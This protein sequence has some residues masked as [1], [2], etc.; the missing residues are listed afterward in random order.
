MS[1]YLTKNMSKTMAQSTPHIDRIVDLN[2]LLAKKSHF[3]LGPRQT[4]KTFLIRH[5]L[6][7]ARVYDLL[8]AEVYL[9]LS[10]HPGRISEEIQPDDRIV[11]I[12]EIQRLP[13]LLNEVHRLI[14][15][16]GLRFLLTGS[17]ARKL[18]RGGI[19]LLGG[20]A[21]TKYLHPLTYK[22]LDTRFDLFQAIKCGLI[23][24]IYFSDE[25]RADLHAYAGSYLQQE[26]MAEGTTRN[27]PAFSRF[28]HVAALC[29]A[30]IVNFTNVANDAQVARTTVYEYFEILKDTLILHE[31]PAWRKSKKRK[32]LASSKYYFFDIGVVSVLQDREFRAGA[33]EFGEAFET[34]LMHELKCFSDYV[35][36]VRLSYW[37]STS[38]FEVDFILGDHTAVEVKAKKNISAN[39]IKPLRMLAEE[40]LLKRYVCVSLEPRRR[41]I[42]IVEILPYQE[43]L[44]LLWD[45]AFV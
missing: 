16:R 27:I 26:I 29:N 11:A 19:N 12:D 31:L 14:E 28:L 24:S 15:S 4:G 23:P 10:R 20:R 33:P 35:S 8:D 39:D 18:R 2:A 30:T 17:S 9:T 22:E 13:E 40:A 45:N 38:G 5:K 7:E 32:P 25:P 1:C 21:R 6:T 44:D 34:Y 3:L 36:G 37:R 42:G 43:F 41:K